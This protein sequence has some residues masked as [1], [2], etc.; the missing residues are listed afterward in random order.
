MEFEWCAPCTYYRGISSHCILYTTLLTMSFSA[1]LLNIRYSLQ[2]FIMRAEMKMMSPRYLMYTNCEVND[3]CL[4][5]TCI[6]NILLSLSAFLPSLSFSLSSPLS[7]P[8]FLSHLPLP[9]F[10]TWQSGCIASTT[11]L[12]FTVETAK[13]LT[14]TP[15][16]CMIFPA[17]RTTFNH[18]LDALTVLCVN[19]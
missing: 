11:K 9:P 17:I 2:F 14:S 12:Y 8:P 7:P 4:I 19:N 1:L 13:I 5:V 18:G 10:L 3:V 15:G 16:R 6:L